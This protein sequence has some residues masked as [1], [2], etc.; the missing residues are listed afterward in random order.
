MAAAIHAHP[1]RYM[2]ICLEKRL[3]ESGRAVFRASVRAHS[4]L[5]GHTNRKNSRK[6]RSELYV[7]G[8]QYVISLLLNN[9]MSQRLLSPSL[10]L[11]V[12]SCV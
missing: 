9:I 11:T 12:R 2:G 5:C 6:Q 4:P 7:V 10:I 8:G 3:S 1:H